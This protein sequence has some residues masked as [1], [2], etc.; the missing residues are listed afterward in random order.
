MPITTQITVDP[1]FQRVDEALARQRPFGDSE[2]IANRL[3][4]V[5]ERR[6]I[7]LADEFPVAGD[8]VDSL[9]MKDSA[10]AR[11]VLADTAVR[12]VIEHL[13]RAVATGRMSAY[14]LT[15]VDLCLDV[16]AALLDHLKA[17]VGPGPL[18]LS[19]GPRVGTRPYHPWIWVDD[20]PSGDPFAKAYR[21]LIE[22]HYGGMPRPASDA[23][24]GAL[25]RGAHLLEELL[26][27]S[28]PSVMGH[29]QVVAVIPASGVWER[30]QS[31]S[32]YL[33]GGNI[34]L[35]ELIFNKPWLV[36]EL[37]YHE[38]IHQKLY[39]FRRGHTVLKE[40]AALDPDS[41]A[42]SEVWVQSPWNY[43]D[44]QWDTHR[45]LAAFH[46]YV[47]VSLL[48]LRSEELSSDLEPIIGPRTG[49]TPARVALDRARYLG[50]KL[51]EPQCW[52]ELDAGGQK[53]VEW[54][55]AVVDFLDKD[56]PPRGAVLHLLLNRY[57]READ[58]VLRRESLGETSYLTSLLAKD[59]PRI[60]LNLLSEL[61]RD[62][63]SRSLRDALDHLQTDDPHQFFA[64]VRR[65]ILG[66][67]RECGGRYDL[68]YTES[69]DAGNV[70]A[71]MI[72]RSS[73][74][75]A[76][77]QELESLPGPEISDV[78]LGATIG[79]VRRGSLQSG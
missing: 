2:C 11:R 54:L 15:P 58:R 38:S 1:A 28:A 19:S 22:A 21:W 26:P 8:I 32:Q 7:K 75:L 64:A 36:C 70:V 3:R 57:E 17:G 4:A 27:A 10:Y 66:A 35:S 56:P 49:Q 31:S 16:L 52:A 74:L 18:N 69:V 71:R 5:Y 41:L 77:G 60:V 33:L 12:T 78:L 43:P 63:T 39:D 44:N 25:Q 42:K 24:V 13:R 72:E 79:D 40:D 6:L 45:V 61:H 48:S 29:T 30:M 65:C 53:L 67:L 55:T 59:E 47:H 46:V 34:F 14:N 51:V 68:P 62:S 50:E 20:R 9:A 73:R 76:L 37:I 23:E